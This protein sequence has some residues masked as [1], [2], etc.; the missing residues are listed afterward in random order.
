[1][2]LKSITIKEGLPFVPSFFIAYVLATVA[3][4][5]RRFKLSKLQIWLAFSAGLP[6]THIQ[7]GF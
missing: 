3:V 6:Q 4:E 5:Y 1:M 7:T 2:G